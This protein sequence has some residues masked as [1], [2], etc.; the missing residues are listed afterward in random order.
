MLFWHRAD[1]LYDVIWLGN[2]QLCFHDDDGVY[3]LY[4]TGIFSSQHKLYRYQRTVIAEVQ[5]EKIHTM[6]VGYSVLLTFMGWRA[7]DAAAVPDASGRHFELELI[8]I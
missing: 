8:F 3:K 1:V 6:V 4:S 2:V 7:V 5:D